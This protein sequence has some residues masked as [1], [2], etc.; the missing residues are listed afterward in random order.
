MTSKQE[1]V[2]YPTPSVLYN[3]ETC[4]VDQTGVFEQSGNVY[5][6]FAS[7]FFTAS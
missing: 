6:F 4:L 7:F 3:L 5:H 1:T 2:H